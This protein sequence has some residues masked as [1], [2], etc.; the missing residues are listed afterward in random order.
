MAFRFCMYLKVLTKVVLSA[1]IAECRVS[2]QGLGVCELEG[3]NLKRFEIPLLFNEKP[4]WPTLLDPPSL[5]YTSSAHKPADGRDPQ[6][7]LK[8]RLILKPD[9]DLNRYRCRAVIDWI[10]VQIDT[11]GVHQAINIQRFASKVLT[12]SGSTSK[13][14]VSG[15]TR[16]RGYTGS[17]FIVRVQQPGFRHLGSLCAE[18][19]RKYPTSA[20]SVGDLA[21][22]GVEVSVDFYVKNHDGLSLDAQNLLRWQ[23]TE[24]LRRHL[25]PDRSLTELEENQP[26]FFA[27][28]DGKGGSKPLVSKGT[29]KTSSTQRAEIV[30][31]GLNE[32]VL[33]PLRI[34]AH[35][36]VPIDTTF[37]IGQKESAVMLRVMNK[38]TDQRDP[39]RGTAVD[40]PPA[41]C[42]SRIEVTFMKKAD[43]VGGPAAVDLETLKDL[44]GYSFKSIRK[45]VFEF[46]HPTTNI[47]DEMADLPFPVNVTELD[48]FKLSGVYGLDRLQRSIAEISGCRYR[49]KEILTKPRSIGLKGKAT[50]FEELNRKIDRSLNRLSRDWT[51]S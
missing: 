27:T 23:M 49:K 34:G 22:A 44:V 9:I 35:E 28:V 33:V 46:F 40:L 48:V 13:V 17:S 11:A 31:L 24:V 26:R 45:L 51:F 15:P 1:L 4:S 7:I 14:Y 41:E 29:A 16:N 50:S 47:V 21:I 37:Y 10:E 38:T 5:H 42:R 30:R 43:E 3:I 2:A 19:L 39:N 8:D 18:L 6:P 36:Q 32:R 12:E 25:R 20:K